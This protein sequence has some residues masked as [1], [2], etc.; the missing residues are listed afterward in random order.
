MFFFF[1]N[2]YI[3]QQDLGLL[4]DEYKESGQSEKDMIEYDKNIEILKKSKITL[5]K[6]EINESTQGIEEENI[7][8]N[9]KKNVEI[10]FAMINEVT[11]DSPA[12]ICGIQLNDLL[13][14]FGPVNHYNHKDLTYLIETVKSNLNKS[15]SLTVLRRN[16]IIP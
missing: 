14:T 10:P 12:F 6:E 9:I 1:K 4:H 11:I 13:I 7:V 2:T 16:D 15:I 3:F 5:Q 8:N